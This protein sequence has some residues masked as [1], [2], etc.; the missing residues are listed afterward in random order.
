MKRSRLYTSEVRRFVLAATERIEGSSVVPAL[1][2]L[3]E[4]Q[5]FDREAIERYRWK[6][7]ERLLEHLY[8]YVPYYRDV[9]DQLGIRPGDI[10]TV[11]N[12]G[13]IP[14][15]AK[16]DIRENLLRMQA[17]GSSTPMKIVRAQTGGT[18]G[19]PLRFL[20]NA[21]CNAFTRAALLRC[22]TWTGYRLGDPMMFLTGGSLLGPP[23]TWKQ[24]AAFRLM[25]YHFMP[26]F[27]L[28]RETLPEY[29]RCIRAKK[30]R[31]LRGFS[32]LIH[33]LAELCETAGITDIRFRAI[34][35]TAEMLTKTQLARIERV[36]Q[37]EV[38]DQYGCAEINALANE[39]EKGGFHINEEHAMVEVVRSEKTGNDGLVVTDL[40]NYAQPFVRYF[41]GDRG[42]I[43]T[44]KCPCGRELIRLQ[45]FLGRSS[46][47]I[48]LPSGERYPG[49]F[50]HHLFG[51]FEG[52][53]QFQVV[54]E[55][56][57]ELRFRLVRNDRYRPSDET[58]IRKLAIE[59]TGIDPELEYVA[60]IERSPS[61][62]ITSVINAV[63][64]V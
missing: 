17:T 10:R 39:C 1:E 57:G 23:Q 46:D 14:I 21:D 4:T 52:V 6:K 44:D 56:R 7:I 33:Q 31:F 9:F 49:V 28:R 13:K 16:K 27:R 26:G 64:N 35:P 61:G 58:E 63:D 41:I 8:T 5:W 22:Y 25:N 11:E 42:S 36:F 30:I 54:Q 18:T 3:D 24:K 37:C 19:E 20:R 60:E 43:A 45:E 62:K 38:F 40:D 47:A 55:K 51:H 50:F 29:V 12:F 32:T 15:V 59:H 48:Y 2:H 34:Y 53:T